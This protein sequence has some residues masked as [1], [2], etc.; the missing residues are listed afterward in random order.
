MRSV[1]GASQAQSA[2]G[3]RRS[4]SIGDAIPANAQ[5][6]R[7][8]TNGRADTPPLA[9]RLPEAGGRAAVGK[10]VLCAA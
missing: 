7:H 1:F 6:L 2:P 8:C 9:W 10:C 3:T 4:A 5:V